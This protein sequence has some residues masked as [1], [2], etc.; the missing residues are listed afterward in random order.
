M[1]KL[2]IVLILVTLITLLLTIPAFA[3]PPTPACNGL[4]VAHGKIHASDTRGEDQ[5]HTLRIANHCH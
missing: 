3:N 2:I 1:K 5:L 4:N